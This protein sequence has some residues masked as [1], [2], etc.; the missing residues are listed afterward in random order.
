[1]RRPKVVRLAS[2][3]RFRTKNELARLLVRKLVRRRLKVDYVLFDNWYAAQQNLD[4]FG[5]LRRH[6]VTR[7]KS[8]LKV[9]YEA[10]RATWSKWPRRSRKPITTTMPDCRPEHGRLSLSGAEIV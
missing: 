3:T 1:M 2:G 5:R 7:A 10:R 8:N 4:L 6:W 9:E